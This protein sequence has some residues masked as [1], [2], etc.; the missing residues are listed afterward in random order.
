MN[1]NS[2]M[3]ISKNPSLNKLAIIS[4][5]PAVRHITCC[6][7]FD[8]LYCNNGGVKSIYV[9]GTRVIDAVGKLILPGG[10]DPNVHFQSPIQTPGTSVPNGTR[11]IDDFYSGT[12]AALKGNVPTY[13]LTADLLT[14]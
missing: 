9:L 3:F 12:K 14:I 5:Y 1:P 2:S 7:C 11:T 13:L 6:C 10:I 8:F 4:S